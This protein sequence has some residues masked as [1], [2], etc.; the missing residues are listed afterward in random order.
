MHAA[1]KKSGDFY[2]IGCSASELTDKCNSWLFWQGRRLGE[3]NE[4]SELR[5]MTLQETQP[6]PSLVK[7][8]VIFSISNGEIGRKFRYVQALVS[9]QTSHWSCG[10]DAVEGSLAGWPWAMMRRVPLPPPDG[11]FSAVC[12]LGAAGMCCHVVHRISII[13]FL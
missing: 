2:S 12:C 13:W 8:P 9:V 7:F 4:C 6:F 10:N 5:E 11:Y 3:G 1:S